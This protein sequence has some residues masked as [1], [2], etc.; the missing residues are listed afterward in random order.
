MHGKTDAASFV[1]SELSRFSNA[2]TELE[3]TWL[4]AWSLYLNTTQSIDYIRS[5][6]LSTV[7]DVN[8]DW[9]HKINTG[10]AFEVVETIHSYLMAAFFP[11]EDW[12]EVS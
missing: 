4:E 11:N 8:D 7:G 6:V 10:K 3:E 9:R 12:F 1:M 5:K 2:R